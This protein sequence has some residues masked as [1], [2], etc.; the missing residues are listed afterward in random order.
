MQKIEIIYGGILEGHKDAVYSLIKG[1]SSNTFYSSGGDGMIV[2]W[3]LDKKG[4]G[5]L[6]AQLP[7]SVYSMLYFPDSG[8]LIAGTRFGGLYV[9]DIAK[10]IQ[11]HWQQLQGDIYSLQY[12]PGPGIIVA[13][14]GGGH[15]HF[16]SSET[17]SILKEFHP[18]AKHCRTTALSPDGMFL[19]TGWSDGKIRVYETA[20]FHET[21]DYTAHLPS[22][23]SLCFSAD[24]K[25]LFSGGRD[26]QLRVW[27]TT[28][29]FLEKQKI[30]AHL[31]TINDIVS[32]PEC[33]LMATA[34]RDK[35][36]KI[37]DADSFELLKVIDLPKLPAHTHSVNKLLWTGYSNTLVS[38][39][40]DKKIRIW[41]IICG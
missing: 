4:E 18:S 33:G 17:F 12:L 23:F 38:A 27:D 3:N 6:V 11:L 34:S 1:K 41:G 13:G 16:I 39:G 14:C 32:I 24:G 9:F 15:L 36:V 35:T 37:W 30:P 21:D 40:D 5:E 10:K 7:S 20:L 8:L 26:A 31:F 22:V 25:K 29:S 2:Q 19:A 28:L